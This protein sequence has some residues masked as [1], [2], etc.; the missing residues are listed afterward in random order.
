MVFVLL[1]LLSG[2]IATGTR[3][4]YNAINAIQRGITTE[5]QIRA[6]FGEP[7]S[8]EINQKLNTKRLTYG[9]R[10]DDSIKKDAAGVGGAV[11]GGVLGHQ[12]GGGSGQTI[13]TGV[14]ALAGGLLANN[15]VNAREESQFLE[16][17]IDLRTGRV[18]DYNYTE[19]KSRT[20]SW[21]INQ[22][23]GTL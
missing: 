5:P 18:S 9:Y 8:V 10:N 22:G 1:W 4:D 6:W 19:A 16:V 15:A 17:L 11:L 3:L 21:S 13:A 14:G 20:Q 12:V 23:V 2:C 7:V